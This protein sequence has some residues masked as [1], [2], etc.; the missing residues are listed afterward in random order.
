MLL[1]FDHYVIGE[2]VPEVE[3]DL[4]QLLVLNS[5]H[6]GKVGQPLQGLVSEH[7]DLLIRLN[8]VREALYEV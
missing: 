3:A 7:L 4:A 5:A 2:E 6:L 1:L 8:T